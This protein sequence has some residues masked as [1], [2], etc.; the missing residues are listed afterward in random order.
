MGPFE[1]GLRETI[2]AVRRRVAY[3]PKPAIQV[4]RTASRRVDLIKAPGCKV[5]PPQTRYGLNEA[6]V[7]NAFY[8]GMTYAVMAEHFGVPLQAMR[9]FLRRRGWKR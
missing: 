9:H 1:T 3:P 8:A 7:R 6:E 4:N 2:S 5:K